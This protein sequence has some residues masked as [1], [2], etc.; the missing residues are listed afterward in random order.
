MWPVLHNL[1][2]KHRLVGG[3]SRLP[4]NMW[5][6][7]IQITI[8]EIMFYGYNCKISARIDV[9][10]LKYGNFIGFHPNPY[11]YIICPLR[12]GPGLLIELN[13]SRGLGDDQ[14]VIAVIC[15]KT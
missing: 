8:R 7:Q 13:I 12:A 5:N 6:N 11:I 10:S 9:D 2:T 15:K 3:F 1:T 14:Q 4:K